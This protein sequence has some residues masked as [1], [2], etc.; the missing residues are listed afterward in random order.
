MVYRWLARRTWPHD[1]CNIQNT[2]PFSQINSQISESTFGCLIIA[3]TFLKEKKSSSK[4]DHCIHFCIKGGV[5]YSEGKLLSP[6]DSLL[7]KHYE[8]LNSHFNTCALQHINQPKLHELFTFGA[9][10]IS[11]QHGCGSGIYTE[12]FQSISSTLTKINWEIWDRYKIS[13]IKTQK[14]GWNHNLGIVSYK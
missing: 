13:E 10:L 7:F 3:F 14:L 4:R 9:A 8:N 1:P 5:N 12:Y 11:T 6:Y 2:T